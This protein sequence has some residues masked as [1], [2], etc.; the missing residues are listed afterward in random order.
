MQGGYF[1]LMF[2]Q[3]V[4][5]QKYCKVLVS[6]ALARTSLAVMRDILLFKAFNNFNVSSV[7]II[8]QCLIY[9]V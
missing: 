9:A 6:C 7:V 1:A 2:L 3:G 4:V 5:S 8:Y